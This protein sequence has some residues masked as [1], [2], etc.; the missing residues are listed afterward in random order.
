MHGISRR[1]VLRSGVGGAVALAGARLGLGQMGKAP[2]RVDGRPPVG[3]R[4]FRSEAIE[5]VIAE[6]KPKIADP[7][8]AKMFEQCFPNT[9][10]TTL[11]TTMRGGVPDTYV[12]T[13]DIDAMWLR[14]S[15]AQVWPICR[16]R[17][18]MH[19]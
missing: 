8:L 4:K 5:S 9:L 13:G 3:A 14:D 18:G 15:S 6:T 19:R 17:G 2:Q 10:D 16:M 11:S 1:D 12:V 7:M